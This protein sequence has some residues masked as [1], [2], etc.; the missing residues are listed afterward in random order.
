[1]QIQYIKLITQNARWTS[2]W[3]T[4]AS[5]NSKP[6]RSIERMRGSDRHA[7]ISTESTLSEPKGTIRHEDFVNSKTNWL[8]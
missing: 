8:S 5:P 2:N 4:K 3:T 6:L 7:K 1:M